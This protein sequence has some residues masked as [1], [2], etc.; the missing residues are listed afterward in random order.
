MAKT[1]SDI[2]QNKK[3]EFRPTVVPS[4]RLPILLAIAIAAL[5]VLVFWPVHTFEFVNYD[6]GD[7]V[8]SNRD[9]Q[10]GITKNGIAWAF[11]TGHAANWHPVTWLSHM[12]DFQ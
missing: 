10:G 8:M 5:T 12:L 9:A 4:R 3:D 1:R 2:S 7:Y 11:T 6:D